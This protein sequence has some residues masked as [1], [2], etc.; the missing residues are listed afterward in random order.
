MKVKEQFKTKFKAIMN[1][2]GKTFTFSKSSETE[3]GL[4]RLIKGDGFGIKSITQIKSFQI[5]TEKRRGKTA[6][7]Y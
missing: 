7:K 6:R 3:Q 2:G 1:V 5:S 4:L